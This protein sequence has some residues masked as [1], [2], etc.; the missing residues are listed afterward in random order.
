MTRCWKVTCWKHATSNSTPLEHEHPND[1]TLNNDSKHNG[2]AYYFC[3][4]LTK[5]NNQTCLLTCHA[6]IPFF[7]LVPLSSL[8][9]VCVYIAITIKQKTHKKRYTHRLI[10]PHCWNTPHIILTSSVLSRKVIFHEKLHNVQWKFATKTGYHYYHHY[11]YNVI[12]TI[13]LLLS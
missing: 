2:Q 12:V 5:T 10:T 7:T 13:Q 4:L 11:I 1:T 6:I 3:I 9:V 8:F